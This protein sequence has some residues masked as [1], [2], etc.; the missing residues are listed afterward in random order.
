MMQANADQCGDAS[1][2][3]ETCIDRSCNATDAGHMAVQ[4]ASRISC[5]QSFFICIHQLYIRE[6]QRGHWL[7]SRICNQL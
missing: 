4:S 1:D 2:G 3:A 6:K 5:I 7:V